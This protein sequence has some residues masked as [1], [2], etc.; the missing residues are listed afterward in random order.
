M[1]ST[2]VGWDRSSCSAHSSRPRRFRRPVSGSRVA[3]SSWVSKDFCTPRV[4]ALRIINVEFA[5]SSTVNNLATTAAVSYRPCRQVRTAS[6]VMA[7]LVKTTCPITTSL[8]VNAAS[9]SM[10]AVPADGVSTASLTSAASSSTA[11]SSRRW[12]RCDPPAAPV[13]LARAVSQEGRRSPAGRGLFRLRL[14]LSK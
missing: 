11:R 14:R 7:I 3:L 6:A 5:A 12:S 8:G 13:R 2:R 9:L 4:N 1:K 10:L